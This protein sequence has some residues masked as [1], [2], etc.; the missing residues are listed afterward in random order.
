MTCVRISYWLNEGILIKL[1]IWIDID[2]LLVGI[3]MHQLVQ[4][5][6]KSYAF[7]IMLELLFAPYNKNKWMELGKLC[8]KC[9]H[10]DMLQQLLLSKLVNQSYL[11]E[12]FPIQ[13]PQVG[14]SDTLIN[15]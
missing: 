6:K 13:W 7:L 15:F 14:V 8:N 1:C 11:G 12:P 4:I 3:V 2:K 10:I 9:R 5:Y